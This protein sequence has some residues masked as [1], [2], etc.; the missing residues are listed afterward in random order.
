M[1]RRNVDRVPISFYRASV[2]T[3]ADMQRECW[4]VVSKCNTCG[5]IMA[6]DLDLVAW[7]S[8]AKTRRHAPAPS[9]RRAPLRHAQGL[10]GSDTLQDQ[11][12]R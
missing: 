2:A 5:L 6:V 7:R 9:C 8:G 10:D 11:D 1:G 3:V 12:P 4:D